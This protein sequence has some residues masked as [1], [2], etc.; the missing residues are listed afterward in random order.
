MKW[1]MCGGE[2]C[3][4]PR[5]CIYRSDFLAAIWAQ[6]ASVIFLSQNFALALKKEGAHNV[7]THI[8]AVLCLFADGH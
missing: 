2:Y 4:A 8:A 7:F 6:I 1:A 5:A 3:D